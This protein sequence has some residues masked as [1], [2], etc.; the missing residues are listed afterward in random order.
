ME[1]GKKSIKNLV[2]FILLIGLTFYILFKDKNLDDIFKVLFTV[3]LKY[4]IIAIICMCGYV[5]CESFNIQRNLKILGEKVTLIR[6]IKYTLINL[7]FSAIT[8]SSTGGQPMEL[9]YMYKDNIKGSSS[10]LVILMQLCG[11][12]IVTIMYAIISIFFNYKYMNGTLIGLFILGLVI[13]GSALAILLI[14]I[15]SKRLS[16]ALIKLAVKFLKFFKIKNVEEKQQSLEIGLTSYQ[17]S[18]EYIKKH[19]LVMLQTVV[20]ACL[21]I[22]FYYSVPYWVY[23]SFGL[24]D[25]SFLQIFT[26]QAVL[27]TTTAG[28]PLPGAVGASE[29]SFLV[30]FRKYFSEDTINSAM[31]LSRGISF[32]L[33]VIISGIVVIVNVLKNKKHIEVEKINEE[34]NENDEEKR[35]NSKCVEQKY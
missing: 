29:G 8:P 5:T 19:K 6:S 20:V 16:N 7:F 23:H 1:K 22:L 30:M 21:Q 12:Q 11:F 28:L 27:Y 33:L 2:I 34:K 32:Y 24:S 31:L 26:M 25:A 17:G 18:A 4:V 10:S 9:Y 13:N 35:E 15:F 14:A 3:N